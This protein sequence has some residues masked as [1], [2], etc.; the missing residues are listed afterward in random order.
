MFE[1]ILDEEK[2]CGY[3]DCD[4]DCDSNKECQ[5]DDEDKESIYDSGC[6]GCI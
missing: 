6:L 5:N 3:S 1:D 4:E 2:E